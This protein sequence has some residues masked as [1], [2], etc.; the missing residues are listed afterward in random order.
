MAKKLFRIILLLWKNYCKANNAIFLYF[1]F[2][3][4]STFNTKNIKQKLKKMNKI[5]SIYLFNRKQDNIVWGASLTAIVLLLLRVKITHSIY[6][7]FLIWN[8]FLAIIPYILSS[9]I[10]TNFF[11]KSKKT[12]NIVLVFVWLVF[13]P[14][15]FYIIT[16]FTHL[17]YHNPFQYGLDFLI[18][19]SFSITGFY[20]GLQSIY[21]I[22]QLAFSKYGSKIGNLFILTISFLSA[23]GIYLGRILR[24]NSWDIIIKPIALVY[25]SVKALFS[26]ETIIYMSQLGLFILISYIVFY[27]WKQKKII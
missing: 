18:I 2:E 27:K 11:K 26:F 19:L 1:N 23:F 4:Q 22:H 9:S 10:H 12:Q 17:H 16:D 21:Q 8:L 7:L 13:I 3:K 20:V 24:F 15:A 5:I 14:N 6:M 25:Q